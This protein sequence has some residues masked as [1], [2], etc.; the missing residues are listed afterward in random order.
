MKILQI[1]ISNL[2]S[3]E[4]ENTIDFTSEPLNGAGIYAITGPTGAG[5][6]TILDALC[7]ALYARTP[8]YVQAK[9]IGISLQDS[10]GENIAQGDPRS[11]LRDG[12]ANGSATVRFVGIDADHYEATWSVRRAH[13]KATGKLLAYTHTLINLTKDREVP[14]TKSVIQKEIERLVGL[15]FDQFTRSVLLAQGDFTAFMKADKEEKSALL[16][17]LTGSQIYSEISQK[18][19][20]HYK[21]EEDALK[22]L[23]NKAA[24]IELLTEDQISEI[25]VLIAD[26][27]TKKEQFQ[28]Q[29]AALEKDIT[30][31]QQKEL[32]LERKTKASE[33][34]NKAQSATDQLADT[35]KQLERVKAV[36]PIKN[37]QRRLLEETGAFLTLHQSK[38]TLDQKLSVMTTDRQIAAENLQKLQHQKVSQEQALKEARPRLLEASTLDTKIETA[39]THLKGIQNN[40]D[41]LFNNKKEKEFNKNKVAEALSAASATLESLQNWSNQNQDRQKIAEETSLI[42]NRLDQARELLDKSQADQQTIKELHLSL[43]SIRS[44]IADLQQQIEATNKE[45]KNLQTAQQHLQSQLSQTDTEDLENKLD[46][47]SETQR[48]LERAQLLFEVL[49]KTQ[50]EKDAT[51]KQLSENQ[52][53]ILSLENEL[54]ALQP[55]LDH[56]AIQVQ[57]TQELIEKATLRHAENTERLRLTL[58]EG[59]P[60]P[61]CGS[62]SHPYADQSHLALGDQVIHTLKEEFSAASAALSMTQQK[63]T[64]LHTAISIQQDQ[65]SRLK[66][67]LEQK[68]IEYQNALKNWQTTS[69][70]LTVSRQNIGNNSIPDFLQQQLK[71]TKEKLNQF[72]LQK[73]TVL[74]LKGKQ[75]STL[76]KIDAQKEQSASL[77]TQLNNLHT[78]S[79]LQS[80]QLSHHTESLQ[81]ASARLKE[82]QNQLNPY[83]PTADW[84]DNWQKSPENFVSAIQKFSADWKSRQN[85]TVEILG[86]SETLKTEI[87]GYER[88]LAGLDIQLEQ[89]QQKVHQQKADM[90]ELTRQRNLL[91]DGRSVQ[92]VEKSLQA[93]I[94]QTEQNLQADKAHADTLEFQWNECAKEL[95]IVKHNLTKAEEQKLNLEQKIQNWIQ[96]FN[97][98]G[99]TKEGFIKL[100]ETE[101]NELLQF[102]DNW[103]TL[104]EMTI[105]SAM[106]ELHSAKVSL[107]EREKDLQ[108]HLASATVVRTVPEINELLTQQ[109]A[110]LE[111]TRKNMLEQQFKLDTDLQNKQK[112]G[113]LQK[114]IDKQ[115]KIFNDWA[116]LNNLI[117]SSDGKKFREIAQQYTLDLL[118]GYANQHLQVLSKR[119]LLSRVRDSLAIQVIDQDMA[120]EVRSVYSLSG[121]ESFLVSLAL[122]LGLASLSSHRL[123]VESLFIDE[124]FGSLDPTTLSI[125]MDALERLHNQGRK[126]GV[127]SHV[128]EMTERIYVQIQVHKKASGK[129]NISIVSLT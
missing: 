106:Q 85:Q 69:Q 128:Q 33:Q 81:A 87:K 70:A 6:S 9:S 31:Q 102:T 73:S 121:G 52:H 123:K 19:Y 46:T 112:Q 55:T 43:A 26:Q 10:S 42:I 12:T 90:E 101:L 38:Q 92:S 61:V 15:N 17:K 32:L 23:Q 74:S 66:S 115:Q 96:T 54:T 116:A 4:G 14:G 89:L 37:D 80:Q 40:Q 34:V 113:T 7:L 5:K 35:V 114:A 63:V 59:D 100:E 39:G 93:A 103:I 13:Q 82:L 45:L 60:C 110:L 53:L 109:N 30:W 77:Q 117:G 95:S 88:E 24:G 108:N 119:Y 64:S 49:L 72:Q 58:T 127:I 84:F 27:L 65:Q 2:A 125:A 11:I 18:I 71:E 111:V 79:E 98:N 22:S 25:K 68:H 36:L 29:I 122:A 50:T 83:F 44:A 16:E 97:E 99:Q 56:L 20:E 78:K 47:L 8:R 104:N 1:K 62:T 91:F 21:L 118:L 120:D 107:S 94:D 67:Q 48:S 75:E 124:G 86:K 129:S 57:T 3:L 76:Q 28:N 51:E 105:H 126:V 41:D